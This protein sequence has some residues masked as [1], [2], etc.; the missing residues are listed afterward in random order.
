MW[1]LK[2]GT[3]ELIYKTEIES[4]P[5]RTN[6]WLPGARREER[7]WEVETDTYTLS[8]TKQVTNKD[9]IHSTGSYRQYPVINHKWKRIG[10][11]I[12]TYIYM[13]IMKSISVPLKLT[14]YCELTIVQV[15]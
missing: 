3:N 4:Q 15:F 14:Q 12:D 7:N 2:K 13:Y 9:L 10:K 11:R 6:L 8:Y 5:E 1:K